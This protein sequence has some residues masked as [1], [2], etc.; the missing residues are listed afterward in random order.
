MSGYV[1]DGRCYPTAS[2]AASAVTSWLP[3]AKSGGVCYFAAA[4]DYPSLAG[5]VV[6]AR[7][8]CLDVATGASSAQS[9]AW[10]LPHCEQGFA[11]YGGE[12]LLFVLALAFAVFSGFRTGYRP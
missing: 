5:E 11:D 8:T 7:L 4:G 10:A 12:Y 9:L 1:V 3:S 2:E 6:S